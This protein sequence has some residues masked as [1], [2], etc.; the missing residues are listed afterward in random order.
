METPSVVG[1]VVDHDS[2]HFEIDPKV[3]MNDWLQIQEFVANQEKPNYTQIAFAFQE[4]E[5]IQRGRSEE[6]AVIAQVR[7]KM[8]V[9]YNLPP[10]DKKPNLAE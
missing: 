7:R 2:S 1:L 10:L 8:E 4:L 6:A 5:L 3:E 9:S